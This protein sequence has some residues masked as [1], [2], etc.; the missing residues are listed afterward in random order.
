MTEEAEKKPT[1]I[2]IKLWPIYIIAAGL[3]LAYALGLQNY[4]TA[5]ALLENA[6]WLD[7]LV[8]NNLLLVLI[9][10]IAIY[11]TATTF[12]V[13]GGILTIA[14]GFLFGLAIGTP[15]TLIGATIG[16]SILFFASKTSVGEALRQIAGPFLG[17]MEKGFN[18]NAFSYM[19]AL[20]LMP[21]FPFAV[22]NIAP[23]LLGAK[24][25]EY[26]ITTFLG[27]IP[28][29][30]AYTWIGAG[31]KGSIVAAAEAGEDLDIGEL[32]SASAA[33]IGPALLVLGVVALIPVAYQKITGRK[34]DPAEAV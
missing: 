9:A 10:Y 11:A 34:A 1:P 17:K 28:G 5:E 12:I 30:L 6:V 19:F 22:V 13:P 23:A 25:R 8:K 24:Y 18:Q 31:L 27:I 20:R 29:T 32:I 15:A 3:G 4:L 7:Q 2:W 26:V 16:A 33:N 14:G 21:I